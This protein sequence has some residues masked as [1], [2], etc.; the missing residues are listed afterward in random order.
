MPRY[1]EIGYDE[2]GADE[3]EAIL[4]DNDEVGAGKAAPY[5]K[6]LPGPPASSQRGPG[7][8][9]LARKRTPLGLGSFTFD[10][11]TG[12]DHEFEVEPQRD[13]QGERLIVSVVKTNALA[14]SVVVKSIL[15]GDISQMASRQA[16]PAEAF[17]PDAVGSELDLSLCKG[18]TKFIVEIQLTG[19]VLGSTD[20]IQVNVGLYGAVVGQ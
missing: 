9:R 15:V 5:R 18:G 16:M 1:D 14:T 13:Y 2:V 19:A 3:Y 11:S 4:G 20:E 10:D 6:R 7:S 12:T 17:Q 8:Q